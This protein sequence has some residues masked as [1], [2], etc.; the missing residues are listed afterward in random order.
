MKINPI[1]K[2][3]LISLFRN[4]YMSKVKQVAGLIVSIML[5]LLLIG[6]IV[7]LYSLLDSKVSVV[8]IDGVSASVPLFITLIAIMV[9][10]YT[11]FTMNTLSKVLYNQNDR[12]ILRVMPLKETEIIIPKLGTMYLRIL[13]TYS[14]MFLALLISFGILHYDDPNITISWWY[15]PLSVVFTFVTPMIIL[16]FAVIFSYPFNLFK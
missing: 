14:L 12:F 9:V 5:N 15:W 11:L 3:E 8:T 7:V 10:A 13:F 2:K 1:V 16:F 4:D 6:F